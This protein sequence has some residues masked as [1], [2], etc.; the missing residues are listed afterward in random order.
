M[1]IQAGSDFMEIVEN[2]AFSVGLPGHKNLNGP[3]WFRRKLL[4]VHLGSLTGCLG[5]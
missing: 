2:P 1:F 5:L 3:F 4:E